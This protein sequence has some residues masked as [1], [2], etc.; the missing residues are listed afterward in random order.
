MT[1]KNLWEETKDH[2][3]KGSACV[4]EEEPAAE[5]VHDVVSAPSSGRVY[6]SSTWPVNPPPVGGKQRPQCQGTARVDV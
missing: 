2:Y 3:A 5:V 6:P 4:D 1:K